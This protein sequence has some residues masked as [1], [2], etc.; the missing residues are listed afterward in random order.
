MRC[1]SSASSEPVFPGA[2]ATRR[3]VRTSLIGDA[4]ND[5]VAFEANEG[6]VTRASS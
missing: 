2:S 6:R 4:H 1:A 5:V 3:Q